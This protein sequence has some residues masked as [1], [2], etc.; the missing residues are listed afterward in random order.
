M[1]NTF[2]TEYERERNEDNEYVEQYY[3]FGEDDIDAGTA[4]EEYAADSGEFDR[5]DTYDGYDG[6]DEEEQ[7][8]ECYV[9]HTY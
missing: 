9:F 8:D 5:Y 7:D 1:L 6:Y 4:A 3:D 2:E